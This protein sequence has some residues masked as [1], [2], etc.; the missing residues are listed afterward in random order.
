VAWGTSRFDYL[1]NSPDEARIFDAF[2]AN[3]PDN[4][5]AAISTAY[6][7]S[8][9]RII[10]DIGGG[11]GETLRRILALYPE[12]RGIVFDRTDVVAAIPREA[13]ASGRI[14]P[15]GGSFFD[16]VPAGADLYLLVRVLHDWSDEDASRILRSCRS[17][18]GMGARLLVVEALIEPD[19]SRGR[20]S[21]YLTD[22]QM[23]AMFG[24][25]RERTET[26]FRRLLIGAGFEFAGTIATASSVAILEAV[27]R[28]ESL[29][30]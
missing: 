26:E 8:N 20:P 23:M 27:P 25:G 21:E 29:S 15:L 9:A 5:H 3:F 12:T 17:A 18:M 2:M 28:P 13:L 16:D 11:N 7:F 14:T 1:R 22:M 30:A 19:P 24:A 6:D 4:R 10:A